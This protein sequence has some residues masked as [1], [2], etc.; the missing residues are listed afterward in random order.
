MG[1]PFRFVIALLC[2]TCALP[3]QDLYGIYAYAGTDYGGDG[4]TALRAPLIQPQGV[5][6]DRDGAIVF[7]DAGDH[8]VRRILAN[9]LVSTIAG[10]GV[11]GE[12]QRL[13]T[14]YGVAIGPDRSIY[15]ADLGNSRV[16]RIAA[17]GTRAEFGD[18]QAPRNVA[19]DKNGVLYVSDFDANRVYRLQSNGAKEVIV[20][21]PLKGP[22]GIAF[23]P[24]GWLY[25]ADS[26]N[27]RVIATKDGRT[28]TVLTSFGSVTSIAVDAGGRLFAAGGDRV[29]VV[30]PT[31]DIAIVNT[32]ADE[33]GL[34]IF[35][36]LITIAKRQIRS[37]RLDTTTT[38]AGD[39]LN[40]TGD[41]RPP[42]E[43]RFLRPSAA[44]RDRF[45][46]LFIADTGNG[47]I[48]RVD[49]NGKLTTIMTAL[50][51][52]AYLALDLLDQL[53]ISDTTAGVIYRIRLDGKSEVF[54]R[55]TGAHPFRRPSGIAFDELGNLYLADTG[56]GLIRKVSVDGFISTVA[57]GG[58]SFTDGFAKTAALQNPAGV[59]VGEDGTI[60]FTEPRR[61]RKIGTDGRVAT[62]PGIPLVDARGLHFDD[63]SHLIVADAGA[64]RVF[65]VAVD[66]AWEAIAGSGASGLSGDDG[67]AVQAALGGPSDAW[68]EADGTILISDTNNNRLRQL[69]HIDGAAP[70]V[71]SSLRVINALTGKQDILSPG[72]TA[73]LEADDPFPFS[74]AT[75]WFGGVKARVVNFTPSRIT[76]V[77][78]DTLQP[79]W[80]EVKVDDWAFAPVE[81]AAPGPRLVGDIENGDGSVNS[82]DKPSP[83][84]GTL[85]LTVMTLSG[86][87]VTPYVTAEIAGIDIAPLSVSN[88]AGYIT[89]VLQLPGGFLPSG[90][91][92]LSLR[93]NQEK[94][95][96]ALD[97]AIR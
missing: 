74:T 73:Y 1:V 65:R 29:A 37:Y 22:A 82:L 66:G 51:G 4:Q 39:S 86:Q 26:G 92:P 48:R 25:I 88:M 70:L 35:G 62:V 81:I 44:I 33:I 41:G 96:G 17:N 2:T 19:V 93:I 71:E 83:R 60:W 49:A 72:Q 18:F 57:G 63:Q 91:T 27:Q 32:F 7:S 34:D 38:L 85:K 68:P 36:S 69:K 58:T 78:P 56:N 15:I 23:D 89:I 46:N 84:T 90:R 52:P 47:R 80:I 55:G 79:G 54:A 45:G 12:G 5:A 28:R 21:E 9:G 6:I 31:G 64:N 13:R 14:P 24:S 30:N 11:A 16:V 94:V 59:A 43:W 75:V 95:V 20:T 40:F 50:S 67:L 77:L 76:V 42:A 3:G 97:V 87:L 10:D 61:L 8:R 53:Y